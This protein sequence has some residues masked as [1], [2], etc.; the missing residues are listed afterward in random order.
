MPRPPAPYIAKPETLLP[1]AGNQYT[2]PTWDLTKKYNVVPTLCSSPPCCRRRPPTSCG[3]FSGMLQ[4]RAAGDT[5]YKTLQIGPRR[6][7]H[8]GTNPYQRYQVAEKEILL[9][10]YA[11]LQEPAQGSTSMTAQPLARAPAIRTLPPWIPFSTTT[12]ASMTP[13]RQT[14]LPSS[15]NTPMS[16]MAWAFSVR[17]IAA[18]G[19]FASMPALQYLLRLS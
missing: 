4:V 14:L 3:C 7:V 2:Y 6:L 8:Q 19:T 10:A 17:R 12:S 16:R 13:P 5:V 1:Q 9:T 18:G 11:N 15:P